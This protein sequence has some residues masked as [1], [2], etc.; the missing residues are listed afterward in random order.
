[1]ST[2]RVLSLSMRPKSLED[3][4]GQDELVTSLKSQF[5]SGRIPHFFI[6]SGPVGAGKTTLA[7]II[8]LLIQ[9]RRILNTSDSEKKSA[10][11]QKIAF[12]DLC[13]DDWDQYK[14][15]DISEI[16]AANKTGVDDMRQLIETMK[17]KPLQLTKAKIVILDEAH[18]LSNSAQN[19]MIT[20]TEDVASHVF[21]IFCTSAINKIIPALKRRAFIITP[22]PL[23]S[24]TVEELVQ[25]ASD[26]IA[27]EGDTLSI[28]DIVVA[29]N[30]N[31]I[32]SPGL[33]LQAAERFFSGIPA[34]ESVMFTESSKLDSMAVCRAVT[35]GK[36]DVCSSLLREA[37]KS[38]VYML[39]SCI[40]G[41]L[42]AILLKSSGIKA[43]N[44]AK[45]MEKISGSSLEDSICLPSFLASLCMACDFLL[46]KSATTVP[47]KSTTLKTV[48]TV[49]KPATKA[50]KKED[51]VKSVASTSTTSPTTKT[52]PLR[53]GTSRSAN[54][55]KTRFS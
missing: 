17:Y 29:L 39:R 24:D 23:S 1:M 22:K 44:M 7:R 30:E 40:L 8:A 5:E 20:E 36:W 50:E 53:T 46:G 9:K 38:D 25:K 2:D 33:V 35:A 28:N 21:Y 52:V 43:Y 3:L 37:T 27:E 32:T 47:A 45:A 51:P 54:P 26:R 16:N 14:K 42:K 12:S 31:D 18:Q 19:A 48:P 34:Q 55:G 13:K 49:G 6:I 10:K 11:K 4:V 41:Y 15:Y